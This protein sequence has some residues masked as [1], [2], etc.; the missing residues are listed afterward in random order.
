MFKILKSLSVNCHWSEVRKDL[1]AYWTFVVCLCDK[2]FVATEDKKT[3]SYSS[4]L[5]AKFFFT[6]L[7]LYTKLVH[8]VIVYLVN[9]FAAVIAIGHLAGSIVVVRRQQNKFATHPATQSYCARA[10]SVDYPP[11][12]ARV[13]HATAYLPVFCNETLSMDVEKNSLQIYCIH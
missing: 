2:K 3:H 9:L 4:K 1:F 7:P 13:P 5:S 12:T 6:L 11:F 10:L 8:F